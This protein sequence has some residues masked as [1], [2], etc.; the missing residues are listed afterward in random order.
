MG[1]QDTL[2]ILESTL[3]ADPSAWSVRKNIV[4]I[5][6]AN[7]KFAEAE[8]KIWLAPQIPSTD[9]DLAFAL[10][11]LAKHRPDRGARLVE[12]I[13]DR[14]RHKPEKALA[15]ARALFK[16]GMLIQ[17]ARFYGFALAEDQQHLDPNLEDWLIWADQSGKIAEALEKP[18]MIEP[19]DKPA[20][21]DTAP[22]PAPS[23]IFAPPLQNAATKTV[24]LPPAESQRPAIPA[25][26]VPARPTLPTPAGGARPPGSPL[27]AAPTPT[28][29][30]PPISRPISTGGAPILRPVEESSHPHAPLP[31][32]P[33][34]MPRPS[35][36][37]S[38]TR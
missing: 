23:Q 31:P 25:A 18:V 4:E 20:P 30:A 29:S 21:P 10:K 12:A 26:P 37:A 17:A 2:T 6:F 24:P 13:L 9:V 33:P 3:E 34:V 32:L 7:G 8:E 1:S 19:V 27:P 5:L 35:G 22:L 16:E 36:P 14:I 28:I 15:I 11:V 38:P